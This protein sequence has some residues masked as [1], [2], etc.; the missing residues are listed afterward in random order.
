MSVALQCDGIP[1]PRDQ[2]MLHRQMTQHN[3]LRSYGF[4]V[5][6]CEDASGIYTFHK[7]LQC[8]EN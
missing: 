7:Q 4:D 8:D 5:H 6:N 2:P 3:T 1:L